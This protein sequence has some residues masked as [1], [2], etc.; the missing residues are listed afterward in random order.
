MDYWI[1]QWKLDTAAQREMYQLISD[2]LSQVPRLPFSLPCCFAPSMNSPLCISTAQ[3][4]G[5]AAI[6]LVY[7]VKYLDT[8]VGMS[9]PA[10]VQK[11]TIDAALSA[12][13]SPVASYRDR[14]KLYEALAKQQFGSGCVSM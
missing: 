5:D 14:S 6:A 8:F 1:K 2:I 10:E 3:D 9:Y 7:L 11:R 13:R 12:V 4:N